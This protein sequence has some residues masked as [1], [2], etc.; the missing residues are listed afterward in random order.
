MLGSSIK[1]FRRRSLVSQKDLASHLDMNL[2]TIA[3]IEGDSGTIKNMLPILRY[4]KLEI[5]GLPKGNDL[6]SRLR[7]SR[8][9]KGWSQRELAVKANVTQPT[10]IQ[11]EKG[12]GRL[13]SFYDVC[14]AMKLKPFLREDRQIAFMKGNNDS[15]NTS[16]DFITKIHSVIPC[17]DLG[18]C[19]NE[20]SVVKAHQVYYEKD[21][22]LA[23]DW[24][25]DFVWLN[26]PYSSM[27]KW[28]VKAYREWSSGRAGCIVCLIPARTNTAYFHDYILN[29]ASV[30]M[31][32]GRLKFGSA[33]IQAPFASMLVMWG[34]NDKLLKK[35][36]A[37]VNGTL[38]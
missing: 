10:I 18:P 23:H 11:L 35:I 36:L 33:D 25:E 30:I 4:L 12:N 14:S 37:V 28:V 7:F 27:E 20:T 26:P 19:S 38:I 17:F 15:W 34:G 21:D 31:I 9:R 2:K 1:N 32:R 29:K 22:G 6:G 24:L 5:A 8:Q 13:S 3:S 16:L